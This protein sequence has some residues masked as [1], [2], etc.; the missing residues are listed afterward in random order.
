MTERPFR[1]VM[2]LMV[3]NEA[4]IIAAM[5]EHHLA[6]GVDH[7]LVTDNGSTDGT[8][9]ILADYERV[10][11]VTVIDEPGDAFRQSQVVTI[12]ARRAATEFGA[13]WVLNSDADEFWV[14]AN[15]DRTL[16]EALASAPTELRSF[17]VPVVNMVGRPLEAGGVLLQHVW[18]DERDPAALAR[19]G[20]HAHPTHNLAHVGSGDVHVANGNHFS[21]LP[22]A[23]DDEVPVDARLEVYHYPW[24]RWPDFEHRTRRMGE[25]H[26]TGDL[27][28]SPRHH[29][30]RDLRWL[31]V[32]LL[33]PFFVARHPD[34]REDGSLA[35]GQR[36]FVR[37]DRM[38]ETFERVRERAVLPEHLEAAFSE[39]EPIG[40]DEAR[41][42]RARHAEIG[43]VLVALEEERATA[44]ERWRTRAEEAAA[45]IAD[46]A[47]G[48]RELE[49]R[50]ATAESALRALTG[51]LEAR[52]EALRRAN[53]Q[54]EQ[55]GHLWRAL[56]RNPIG[57]AAMLSNV[58]ISRLRRGAKRALLRASE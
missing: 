17:N 56:K 18:R 29:V 19:V 46:D 3:R 52:G 31:R 14:A 11:P 47:K 27:E 13:T 22:V 8:R 45:T 34:L 57:R 21:S 24:R 49:G 38:R 58:G 25:V 20:L 53:V 42:L 41:A 12:M 51:Q 7:I 26:E 15:R 37:D 36:G 33:Q 40:A 9:E 43:G 54:L 32:G 4:D 16:A 39:P 1:L 55:W 23:G 35:D 10:A 6:Q 44:V 28:P 30:M 50:L 48:R 2:T 5:L